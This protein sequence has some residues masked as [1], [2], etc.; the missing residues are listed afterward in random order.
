MVMLD[1]IIE[2]LKKQIGSLLKDFEK[3]REW[4]DFGNWL[5]R[6]QPVLISNRCKDL[7]HKIQMA[8]RLAQCLN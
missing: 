7:P 1:D 8:K 2:N 4:A 3:N 6:L 5:S